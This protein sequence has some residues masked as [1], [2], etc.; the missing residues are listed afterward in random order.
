ML[1]STSKFGG[2][3]SSNPCDARRYAKDIWTESPSRTSECA[4]AI[5]WRYQV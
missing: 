5:L 2:A 3:V 4:R 1:R